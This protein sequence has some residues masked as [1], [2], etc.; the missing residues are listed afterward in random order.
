[1]NFSKKVK[2]A[3][4][5]VEYLLRDSEE[6]KW[7]NFSKSKY[8]NEVINI[9]DSSAGIYGNIFICTT[10]KSKILAIGK[11]EERYYTDEDEYYSD[12]PYFLSYGNISGDEIT[13][14]ETVTESEFGSRD[15]LAE[16]YSKINIANMNI[17]LDDIT[18]S[19]F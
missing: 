14:I 17:N 18:N 1:M 12:Y 13:S 6:V 9:S 3:K 7:E 4:G 15:K 10:A 19:F 2:V 16:L 5:L 8:K 11:Y